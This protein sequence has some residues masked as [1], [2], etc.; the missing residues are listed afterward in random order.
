MAPA[1]A[2]SKSTTSISHERATAARAGAGGATEAMIASHDFPMVDFLGIDVPQKERPAVLPLQIELL[3]EVAIVHLAP[4]A[5]A[6]RVPAHQPVDCARIERANQ[7]IHVSIELVAV[8]K[9]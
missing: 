6:D 5:H 8:A 4:P 9:I 1:T 7:Q 3:V 2:W